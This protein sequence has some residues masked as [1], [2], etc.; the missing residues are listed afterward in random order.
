[1]VLKWLGGGKLDHPMVDEK[2]AKEVLASLPQDDAAKAVEEICHWIESVISTE[3]FKTERRA[4]LILQLDEAAQ[5]AQQKLARDYLSTPN[6]SKFQ[7]GRLRTALS[8]LSSDLATAYS[9]CFDQIAADSGSAGRLKPQMPLLATRAV[10]SRAT[11][12]KWRYMHYEMGGAGV[13]EAFGK[14]YRFAESKKLQRENVSP[15]PRMNLTTSA[16]REFVKALMLAASSPDCLMPVEIELAERIIANVSG[17]FLISDVHQPQS[18]YNWIDLGGASPPKRLTQTPPASPGL[19]YFAAG[20]ANDKVEGWIRVTQGGA[21]PTDLNLG[22]TY[23][24]SR[25]LDVLR[26]LKA[27]WA[28]TPPVRKHDRYEVE[29]RLSVVNGFAGV[30][31]R[32]QDGAS[33]PSPETWTTRNISSG[34]IGA[35]AGKAHGD[36]LGIGRLVGLSVEGGSGGCSVGMVRRCNR[37]EQREMFVGVRT[38]AKTAFPIQLG[39]IEPPEALL[40]SDGSSFKDEALICLREGG[41]D[42]RV[43]P[44][45]SI[46]GRNYLLVPVERLAGGEDFEIARYRAMQQS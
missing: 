17:S 34:G 8:A 31:A 14:T 40:L 10:R 39:G 26:H 21:V 33:G 36:W 46:E 28:A 24:A 16:E 9:A 23:E 5:A 15:Y 43:S 25:V 13:W 41:F 11:Q 45:M 3:G 35:V 6:M 37:G 19:R 22:G 20:A 29:H 32:V 1:M 30:R 44:T 42:Q 18:T 4:E 27:N 7:E 38:Y 12:L 2:G